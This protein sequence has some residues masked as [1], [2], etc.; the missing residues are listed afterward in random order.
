MGTWSLIAI[1][2]QQWRENQGRMVTGVKRGVYTF[3]DQVVGEGLDLT[4]RV[5]GIAKSALRFVH[6]SVTPAIPIRGTRAGAAAA[7]AKTAAAQA[8]K[9]N[10]SLPRRLPANYEE[11]FSL[12]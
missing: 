2:W 3:C 11:G 4:A 8:A 6:R 10:K 7:A 5:S 12:A 1:P 9:E